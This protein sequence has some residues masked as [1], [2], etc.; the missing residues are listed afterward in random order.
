VYN[1]C[2]GDDTKAAD[3]QRPK[4][5]KK[6]N[7]IKYGENE[8]H[9]G[10]WNYYTLQCGRWLWDDMLWNSPKHS[11]Y[12]NSTSGFNLDHITTVD[13][14]FCTSLRNFIHI[15]PPSAEKNDV[16]S[17]NKMADLSPLGFQGSNN[18]FFEKPM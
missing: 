11:P 7:K 6:Q 4:C 2:I 10:G 17:V 16:M 1:K 18:G 13:M 9:Y 3:H 12:S 8:F 14:S 15:R 5:I